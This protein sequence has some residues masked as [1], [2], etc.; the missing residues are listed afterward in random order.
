MVGVFTVIIQSFVERFDALSINLSHKRQPTICNN[1]QT[2]RRP[3]A[4]ST[5]S[6]DY[7]SDGQK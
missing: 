1:I 2:W 5:G 7:H 4:G 6:T 3:E